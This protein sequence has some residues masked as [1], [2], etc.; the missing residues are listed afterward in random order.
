MA[1]DRLVKFRTSTDNGTGSIGGYYPVEY[2]GVQ[3]TAFDT[4]AEYV[5]YPTLGDSFAASFNPVGRTVIRVPYSPIL[6]EAFARLRQPPHNFFNQS[7][8]NF[9]IDNYQYDISDMTIRDGFRYIE[10]E[11]SNGQSLLLPN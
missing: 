3:Y 9:S 1:F 11:G 10:I 5:I 6:T 7:W 2:N 4:W 8:D